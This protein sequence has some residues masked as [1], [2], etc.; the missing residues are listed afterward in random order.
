MLFWIIFMLFWLLIL[1]A[2]MAGLSAAPWVPTRKR[3]KLLLCDQLQ[4]SPKSI[5]YDL[6]CGTGTLLIAL[7]QKHPKATFIGCEISVL[8]YLI[9]RLRSLKYKNVQIRFRNLFK[10]PLQDAD[11]VIIFLLSKAYDRLKAKFITELKDDTTIVI[12]AW[13]LENLE[14]AKVLKTDKALPF[15]LYKGSDFR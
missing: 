5:V 14:P 3:E 9:A 6:G 15:Y 10:Q 13:P 4:I 12:Q 11:V 8:P 7:A 2:A 1:S